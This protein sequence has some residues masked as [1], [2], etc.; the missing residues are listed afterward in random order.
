MGVKYIILYE[1]ITIYIALSLFLDAYPYSALYKLPLIIGLFF[2]KDIIVFAPKIL[3][4]LYRQSCLKAFN[5][6]YNVKEL[7]LKQF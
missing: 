7:A 1:D 5:L 2:T 4:R 6:V 3:L